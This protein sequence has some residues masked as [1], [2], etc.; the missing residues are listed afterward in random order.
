[1]ISLSV[2]SEVIKRP[3]KFMIIHESA[4]QILKSVQKTSNSKFETGFWIL[5][6]NLEQ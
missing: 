4:F 5:D 3:D 6:W 2:S 1:M